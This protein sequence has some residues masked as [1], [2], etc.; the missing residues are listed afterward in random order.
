MM[1]TLFIIYIILYNL[2]DDDA[3]YE[4]T[5]FMAVSNLLAHQ[6]NVNRA[7]ASNVYSPTLSSL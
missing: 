6:N 4:L 3:D 1:F 7:T 2:S 5:L